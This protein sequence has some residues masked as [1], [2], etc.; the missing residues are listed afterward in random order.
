MEHFVDYLYW[1]LPGPPRL[2][3]VHRQKL[4]KLFESTLERLGS[5]PSDSSSSS[6]ISPQG[7]QAQEEQEQPTP[8]S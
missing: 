3:P 7:P 8:D 1:M 4:T 5:A 2:G 6:T